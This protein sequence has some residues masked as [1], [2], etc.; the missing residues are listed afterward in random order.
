MATP[1]TT[2][3]IEDLPPP[4]RTALA[5][6][7]NERRTP[8]MNTSGG[9]FILAGL[10]GIGALIFALYSGFGEPY[11]HHDE[12]TS[13]IWYFAGFAGIIGAVLLFKRKKTLRQVLGF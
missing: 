7:I 8:L 13:L 10:C 1:E 11:R 2:I 6:A 3:D 9:G 4:A 12:P 5:R